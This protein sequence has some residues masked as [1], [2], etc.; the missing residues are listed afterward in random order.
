MKLVLR[1]VVG[2]LIAVIL[3]AGCQKQGTAPP[4]SQALPQAAPRQALPTDVPPILG[5]APAV[6]PEALKGKWTAVKLQVEDKKANRLEEYVVKLGGE[7]AIPSSTLV[8]QAEE[9][10]PDLKIEG[11]SFTT[12][13]NELKNPAVHVRILDDGKE[14]FNGWLFQLFPSVHPFQHERYGITLRDSVAAS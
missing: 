7:L 5:A 2:L 8:V 11:S 14:V 4:Q 13:S 12:A 10:L 1:S 3:M 9:F 6:I